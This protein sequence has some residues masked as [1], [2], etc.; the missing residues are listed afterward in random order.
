MTLHSFPARTSVTVLFACVGAA[1][2][3]AAKPPKPVTSVPATASFDCASPAGSPSPCATTEAV[4][5]VA[6]HIVDEG[7]G[8][9][10]GGVLGERFFLRITGTGRAIRLFLHGALPD[11][12]ECAVPGVLAACNPDTRLPSLNG[13]GIDMTDAEV[14]IVVLDPAPSYAD[15]AGGL[16]AMP[17]DGIPRLALVHFTTWLAGGEGHWGVNFN[18][19]AYHS[20]AADVTREGPTTWVV[21]ASASQDAELVS[22]NHSG[23][24]R[25]AGPSHEGLYSVPFRLTIEATAPVPTGSGC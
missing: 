23:I 3:S 12:L 17:C 13:T 14:S 7:G 22:F 8:T 1:W 21:E 19:R 2:L 9:Y 24:R 10:A 5:P 20:S 16:V 11:S 25:K 4:D 15:A 18:P 6:H